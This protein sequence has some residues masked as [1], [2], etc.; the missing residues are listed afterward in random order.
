MTKNMQN[1]TPKQKSGT[2]S[3]KKKKTAKAVLILIVLCCLF[4]TIA[5]ASYGA[6]NL[7]YI[8]INSFNVDIGNYQW[9]EPTYSLTD[10]M[11]IVQKYSPSGVNKQRLQFRLNETNVV[12]LEISFSIELI[13]KTNN[14]NASGY[15]G[16]YKNVWNSNNQIG[17]FEYNI[18]ND[19][20]IDYNFIYLEEIE[21][22]TNLEIITNAIYLD[23]G[24]YVKNIK[25]KIN[26][27]IYYV[28]NEYT[29]SF[30]DLKDMEDNLYNIFDNNGLNSLPT[31]LQ[32]MANHYNQM[33][34]DMQLNGYFVD[35][36]YF[37][38]IFNQ[39]TIFIAM[40]NITML[41]SV[42]SYILF[43]KLR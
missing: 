29:Q 22:L 13:N 10:N 12:S 37:D 31:R 15:T 28:I 36:S 5:Q 14:I 35:K 16:V 6:Q 18:V 21:N 30:N 1:T 25:I 11:I 40:M 26:N 20:Q 4:S 38:N 41:I 9:V 27:E 34:T 39:S 7:S 32:N 24:I 17:E 3:N 42:C 2:Y 19:Y 23:D 33:K 43:G 8:R